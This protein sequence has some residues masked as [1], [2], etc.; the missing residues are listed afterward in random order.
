VPAALRRK[1]CAPLVSREVG[2]SCGFGMEAHGF[3]VV[4]RA[5]FG[6][7]SSVRRLA[8]S[9]RSG[10]GGLCRGFVWPW[11]VIRRA[12]YKKRCVGGRQVERERLGG[13]KGLWG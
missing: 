9:C 6:C 12:L 7:A 10:L 13:R 2:K 4:L 3:S 1:N 8:G 11:F 5:M